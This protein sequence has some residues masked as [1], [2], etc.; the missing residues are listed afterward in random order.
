M[1][2][3]LALLSAAAL[4]AGTTVMSEATPP[5]PEPVVDY[6][7]EPV[8]L[9]SDQVTAIDEPQMGLSPIPVSIT[10]AKLP[11]PDPFEQ[12]DAAGPADPAD[13]PVCLSYPVAPGSYR[14]S[15]PYG[16]RIHPIFGSY[17]MHAGVDFAAPLGTPIHAVTDGTVV[18]TGAGR[19][20]RSSELVILEH[21]VGDTTFYSWYVHMYPDGVFVE[22]GQRVRAGEVIAEVGNNGNST[23][24]HLH[25]E[26]HTE[27]VVLS[28]V[29]RTPT[30]N[31][32]ALLDR[33]DDTVL[34][35]DEESAEDETEGS[36]E[37]DESGD[38][39]AEG[40]GDGEAGEP[41]DDEAEGP[42]DG[43]TEAPTQEPGDGEAEGPGDGETEAPTQEPGDGEAEGPGDGETEAPTQ[44]P[45]DGEAEGPG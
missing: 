12:A 4:L 45:G 6:L 41:G 14:I 25:F 27:D 28:T 9:E 10:L 8:L 35:P 5:E 33:D 16:Y 34:D 31:P 36:A 1:R 21:T 15:S 29:P 42:G 30:A 7:R 11:G 20:G 13:D 23:G 2:R 3:R 32:V 37:D 22:V 43:E 19:L 24:P 38:G 39:E 17:A 26:I 40:P 44:E 18:Y